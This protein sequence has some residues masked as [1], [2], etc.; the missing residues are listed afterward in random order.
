MQAESEPWPAV[1]LKKHTDPSEDTTS[2]V[3]ELEVDVKSSEETSNRP[4]GLRVTP[5]PFWVF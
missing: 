3:I 1:E 5:P 4:T 2:A